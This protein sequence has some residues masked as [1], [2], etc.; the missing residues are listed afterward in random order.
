MARI[1]ED[2][3]IEHWTLIGGELVVS[4]GIFGRA[5]PAVG[6]AVT[7][8]ASAHQASAERSAGACS[9]TLSP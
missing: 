8:P 7:Q 3:L 1:D 9:A 6:S 2:E 4:T 5:H